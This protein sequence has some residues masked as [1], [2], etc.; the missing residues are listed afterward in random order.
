MEEGLLIVRIGIGDVLILKLHSGLKEEVMNSKA[1]VNLIVFVINGL[2]LTVLALFA[3]WGFSSVILFYF[4]LS[5]GIISAFWFA[6][7][8]GKFSNRKEFIYRSLL[9][10]AFTYAILIVVSVIQEIIHIFSN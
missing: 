10:G 6:F 3:V 2:F 5:I 1:L 7:H 4:W 8:Y 9:Y